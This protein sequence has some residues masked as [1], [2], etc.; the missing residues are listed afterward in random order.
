MYY[1]I[2][3]PVVSLIMLSAIFSWVAK[4]TTAGSF[5][6]NHRLVKVGRDLW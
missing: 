2:G 1:F 5:S 4:G 6:Q 3:S